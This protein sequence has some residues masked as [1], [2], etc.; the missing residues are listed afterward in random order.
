[1]PEARL[2]GSA[3]QILAA[4][5]E[6]PGLDHAARPQPVTMHQAAHAAGAPVARLIAA[7]GNSPVLDAPVLVLAWIEGTDNAPPPRSPQ[8][9]SPRSPTWTCTCPTCSSASAASPRSWTAS[10]PAGGTPLSG[11]LYWDRVGDQAMYADY[12]HRL[13]T[14]LAG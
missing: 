14:W 11:L 8:W 9:W 3:A 1:M 7:T 13:A 2:A 12:Q 10:T 5:Q 6:L 4:V